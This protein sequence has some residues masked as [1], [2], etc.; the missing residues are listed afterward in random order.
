MSQYHVF[1]ERT[2]I[3]SNVQQMKLSIGID[4]L[5]CSHEV[6][7]VLLDFSIAFP[8]MQLKIVQQSSESLALKLM[9]NSLDF[10]LGLF[11]R[12]VNKF[13]HTPAYHLQG[14]WVA[15]PLY[16]QAHSQQLIN[17]IGVDS[18]NGFAIMDKLSFSHARFLLPTEALL[19]DIDEFS[20]TQQIWYVEDLHTLLSFC[21]NGL[22]I[23]FLPNFVI[24]NDLDRGALNILEFDVERQGSCYCRAS[25]IFSIGYQKSPAVQWLSQHFITLCQPYLVNVFDSNKLPSNKLKVN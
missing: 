18:G 3:I 5:V 17:K 23:A 10:A 4:P 15:S 19:A 11:S 13:D 1:V 12:D 9:D 6:D 20:L 14:S 22:G 8:F 21:R 7:Q 24:E 25:L 2:K 16:L